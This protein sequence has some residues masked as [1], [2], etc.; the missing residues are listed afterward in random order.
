MKNEYI[1]ED[2]YFSKMF[3]RGIYQPDRRLVPDPLSP[4]D[5]TPASPLMVHILS[6]ELFYIKLVNDQLKNVERFQEQIMRPAPRNVICWPS[7]MIEMD[8]ALA[9]DTKLVVSQHYDTAEHK[10]S[11]ADSCRVA[12]LFPYE[13]MP[14]VLPWDAAVK[15]V[16]SNNYFDQATEKG[17]N[18][19]NTSIRKFAVC[20]VKALQQLNESGYWYFDFHPDRMF[21]STDGDEHVYLDYS[22]LIY[23][24]AELLVRQKNDITSPPAG[25]YPV[26]FAEPAYIRGNQEFF[27]VETQNYNLTAFLFRLFYGRYAYEGAAM[28]GRRDYSKESHYIWFRDYYKHPIFIFEPDNADNGLNEENP[29]DTEQMLMDLWYSSPEPMRE[30][31]VATLNRENAER[32]NSK[33]NQVVVHNPMPEDWLKLFE[34]FGWCQAENNERGRY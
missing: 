31:F 8:E 29:D 4:D 11:S 7:D 15:A 28:S 18:W 21:V 22:N 3:G 34:S 25:W 2:M 20:L 27:D 12:L 26:E 30:M 19:L 16:T 13:E 1:K 24:K 6:G 14:C 17:A 9:E 33:G 32:K 5:G 10:A 23:S